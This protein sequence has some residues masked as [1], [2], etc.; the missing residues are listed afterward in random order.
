MVKYV[1]KNLK[2]PPANGKQGPADLNKRSN[3]ILTKY[4]AERV[5]IYHKKY[6]NIFFFP[7]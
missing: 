3:I 6:K 7:L 2:N 4:T 5:R 1:E